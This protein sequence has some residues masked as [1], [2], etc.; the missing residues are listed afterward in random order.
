MIEK[1]TAPRH[2][3]L[4][5]GTLAFGGGGI[6]CTVR[7]LSA[8]GARVDIASPLGLPSNFMLVIEADHFIRRCRPVWNNDRQ[9]GVAF[10]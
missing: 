2:R 6:D 7:N 8:S 3:V 1:R 10:E 5:R 9:L 4:K